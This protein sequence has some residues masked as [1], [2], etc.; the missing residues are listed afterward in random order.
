MD[1]EIETWIPVKG[2]EGLY[3]CSTL[4]RIRSLGRFMLLPQCGGN[5]WKE[6]R[7]LRQ[8]WAGKKYKY[9]RVVLYDSS[10]NRHGFKVHSAIFFSFNPAIDKVDNLQIDHKDDDKTNNRPENLQYVTCRY[11]STKRSLNYK[12]RRCALPGI[13]PCG[14]KFQSRIGYK[15]KD[16]YLGTYATEVEAHNAYIVALNRINSGIHPIQQ[17]ADFAV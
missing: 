16:V 13:S 8:S 6:G 1:Q 9:L 17:L 12:N 10:G 5:V 3:E 15:S 11:N 14:I 4:G 2:F 7:I